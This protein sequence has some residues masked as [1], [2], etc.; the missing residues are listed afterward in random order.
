MSACVVW[1]RKSLRLHDNPALTA[2]CQEKGISSIIPLYVLDPN[3]LG[4]DFEKFG[5]NRLS[6]L[7][8]SLRDLDSRLSTEYASKLII[9]KGDPVRA[10]ECLAQKLGPNFDSLYCEYGSE[11]YER[12]T[13]S[14]I[15]QA[16]SA[17]TVRIRRSKHSV[18]SRPFWTWKKQ[19][20]R[21]LTSTQSR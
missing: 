12:E 11:P 2:A 21:P 7:F 13:F 9:L 20:L 14:S 15:E 5:P 4:Q 1:F 16:P 8:E 3:I 17:K 18:P 19:L 10:L 6:F